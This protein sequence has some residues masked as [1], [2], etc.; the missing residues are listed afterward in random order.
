MSQFGILINKRLRQ[1]RPK[2]YFQ[3]DDIFSPKF[4]YSRAE[5]LPH[6]LCECLYPPLNRP[7][8]VD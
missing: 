3:K 5:L 8:G 1:N 6:Q 2:R 4:I 7:S